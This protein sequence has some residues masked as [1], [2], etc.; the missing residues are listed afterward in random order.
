MRSGYQISRAWRN[1]TQVGVLSNRDTRTWHVSVE[2][3]RGGPCG[4]DDLVWRRLNVHIV[5]HV[6]MHVNIKKLLSS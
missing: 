1:E 2:I 3:F 6:N 5:I 4:I